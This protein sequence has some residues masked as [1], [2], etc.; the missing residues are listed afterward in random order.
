VLVSSVILRTEFGVAFSCQIGSGL[1]YILCMPVS[2][3]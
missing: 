3:Y 1:A 2:M